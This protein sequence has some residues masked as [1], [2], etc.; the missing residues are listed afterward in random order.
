MG[1]RTVSIPYKFAIRGGR[2]LVITPDQQ[3]ESKRPD[4]RNEL[5]IKALA[6]GFRWR[7]MLDEGK[8][9]T[10]AEISRAENMSA[11]YISRVSRLAL[12]SPRIVEAILNGQQPRLLDLDQLLAPFPNGWEAQLR[13]FGFEASSDKQL[14]P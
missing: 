3:L 2:K 6:R 9:Q 12:L 7:Q 13:H 5:L 4:N 8:F 1:S 14:R 10:I 11:S